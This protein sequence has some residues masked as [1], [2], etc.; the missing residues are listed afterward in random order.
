[1]TQSTPLSWRGGD[2]DFA[3]NGYL[4]SWFSA[5]GSATTNYNIYGSQ[6]LVGHDQ[7]AGED[8]IIDDSGQNQEWAQLA[9]SPYGEC[10]VAYQDK[11]PDGNDF[12][13]RG[14]FVK[15]CK[16]VFLPLTLRMP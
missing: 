15:L 7:A 5:P 11:S 16:Q 12:E 10:L 8:F 6:V 2:V 4:A 9:C 1:L 13:I 3:G 14:R